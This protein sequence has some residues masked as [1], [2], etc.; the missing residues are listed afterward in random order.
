MFL[1]SWD[2]G[3]KVQ[4]GPKRSN[5]LK[6]DFLANQG[7]GESTNVG[8]IWKWA[9]A[10]GEGRGGREEQILLSGLA[11]VLQ[12]LNHKVAGSIPPPR[13]GEEINEINK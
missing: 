12:A 2:F 8:E 3:K 7:G 10:D 11:R 13:G 5:G 9:G 1:G 6:T 4:K